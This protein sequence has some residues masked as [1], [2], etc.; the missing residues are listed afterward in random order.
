MAKTQRA[1]KLSA[2]EQREI[3][4]HSQ[5]INDFDIHNEMTWDLRKGVNKNRRCTDAFWA[6]LFFGAVVTWVVFVAMFAQTGLTAYKMHGILQDKQVGVES[7]VDTMGMAVGCGVLFSLIY[8]Y[9]MSRFPTFMCYLAVI[10]VEV[11]IIVFMIIAPNNYYRI[12][13]GAFFLLFNCVLCCLRNKFALA[14]AVIDASADFLAATK[15]IILLD[16]FSGLI[17]AIVLFWGSITGFGIYQAAAS[18]TI[19]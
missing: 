15:R 14:I 9:M 10:L 11:A 19:T 2:V 5:Q 12:G 3:T 6:V 1:R 7:M 16:L 8:I 4:R 18:G 13:L 17:C